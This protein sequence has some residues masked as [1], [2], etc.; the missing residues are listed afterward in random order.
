MLSTNGVPVMIVHTQTLSM[1]SLE[2]PPQTSI[3]PFWLA[4]AQ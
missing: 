2:S 4:L 1:F 3:L